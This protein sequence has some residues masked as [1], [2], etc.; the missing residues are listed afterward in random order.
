MAH[1]QVKAIKS[2]IDPR[3]SN[4]SSSTQLSLSR[5]FHAL[6]TTVLP[7]QWTYTD[8][9]SLNCTLIITVFLCIHCLLYV[10]NLVL[11]LNL[12]MAI[13]LQEYSVSNYKR[14]LAQPNEVVYKVGFLLL[15]GHVE[16]IWLIYELS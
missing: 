5:N 11:F 10:F 2:F 15:S 12:K 14:H 9:I 7:F 3:I 16:S 1:M 8:A 13:L 6:P 4:R